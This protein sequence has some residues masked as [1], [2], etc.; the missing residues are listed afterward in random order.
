VD[1]VAADSPLDWVPP[2][3]AVQDRRLLAAADLAR[4]IDLTEALARAYASP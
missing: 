2:S 4:S 1:V 3:P